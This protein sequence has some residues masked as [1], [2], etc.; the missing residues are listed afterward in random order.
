M[1]DVTNIREHG[2]Q[3]DT[4]CTQALQRAIDRAGEAG[5]TVFVPPG[6]WITGTLFLRGGVTLNLHP[7]AILRGSPDLADYRPTTAAKIGD[8]HAWHLIAADHA[9]HVTITGGGT[10][11][12]NG[13]AFWLDPL[14]PS[15]WYR[16]KPE[17]VS[18]MLDF[19]W[20]RHLRLDDVRI[21]NSPGW[22]VH[23]YCCDDVTLRGV[24][25]E[26]HLLGPNTDGFDI[27]GCRD[28]FISD[29]KLDCGDDAIIIKATKDA[30]STE[31]VAISNCIVRTN[32]IGIG[33][34]QETESDIRQVTVSN[35]VMKNCHRMFTIGIWAGG[36]V[37]DVVVTGCVGDTLDTFNLARPIQLEVKQHVGWDVPLGAIRNV[38]ISNFV[39]RTQGRVLITAQDGAAMEHIVL[40]DV[41]LDYTGLD[42]ADRLS[43]KDGT[44]SNQYANRNPE[45]RRK[46]AALIVENARD[47]TA[48]GLRVTW[49]EDTGAPGAE[50]PYAAVWARHV[51][52]GRLDLRQAGGH[53]GAPALQADDVTDVEVLTAPAR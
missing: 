36:T 17:R 4:L 41:R 16:A 23:P 31:R 3:P 21:V 13:P 20:C 14:P 15:R 47:F 35:C 10:L 45:A 34:G 52:G 29:C 32:C 22:T 48:D 27:N 46:H 8:R 33:I 30:R 1:S 19:A 40:R 39:A 25:V 2:A 12:G 28:V 49:P 18:P 7:A 5:G 53:R 51:R 26:N 11:D 44:G 24:R 50:L 37:E 38:Q 6:V 43:P 9:D 42:D